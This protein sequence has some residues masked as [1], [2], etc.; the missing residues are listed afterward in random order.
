[1]W[2]ADSNAFEAGCSSYK[3]VNELNIVLEKCMRY[4]FSDSI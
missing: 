4:S 1:M 3:Y 2:K